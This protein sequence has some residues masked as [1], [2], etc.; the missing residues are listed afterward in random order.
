MRKKLLTLTLIICSLLSLVGCNA[1]QGRGDKYTYDFKDFIDINIFGAEGQAYIQITPKEISVSDFSSEEEYIKVKKVIDAL[2]LYYI[3]G[4]NT[5]AGLS[6]S[7]GNGI[8]SGD[9]IIIS[10]N[11]NFLNNEKATLAE[12][13]DLNIEE[14]DYIVEKLPELKTLDLFSSEVVNFYGLSTD[15]IAYI[16]NKDNNNL[17]DELKQNLMYKITPSSTPLKEK[18][19]ILTVQV[20]LDENLIKS[21]NYYNLNIYFA[22]QNLSVEYSTEKVLNKIIMPIDFNNISAST[23]DNIRKTL[24]KYIKENLDY[25]T[26]SISNIQQFKS[27][28]EN[29]PYNYYVIY[30]TLDSENVERVYRVQMKL[31]LIDGILNILSCASPENI[32]D[33]YLSANYSGATRLADFEN[34]KTQEN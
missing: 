34:F 12:S 2:N 5:S 9:M 23:L 25:N 7:K 19:T 13:I 17:S 26:E 16:I 1:N 21:G 28:E 24:Y 8:K 27:Q 11:S 32:M 29:E 30:S 6:V 22:K 3:P 31:L 10:L 14:Y 15:E 18:Q 33:T 4:S 20:G